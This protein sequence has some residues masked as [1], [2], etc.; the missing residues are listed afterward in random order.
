MN[1]IKIKDKSYTIEQIIILLETCNKV[2]SKNAYLAK[3]WGNCVEFWGSHGA[4][5]A[6]KRDEFVGYRKKIRDYLSKEIPMKKIIQME[7]VCTETAT[8]KAVKEFVNM[9]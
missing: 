4:S 8:Q 1:D 9:L 3:K 7:K 5:Y 6:A 2:I